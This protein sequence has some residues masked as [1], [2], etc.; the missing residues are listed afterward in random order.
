[1]TP[2]L[3]LAQTNHTELGW[4][5]SKLLGVTLTSAEWVLWVLV[6]L[7][8]LSIA[9]MLE[10]TVYFARH[11]LPD[12]EALAVRLAR[13]EYDVARKAIEGKTG[14]E[15][16]IIRE[17]LASADQGADTVEQVIASTLSRERPQYERFLSYLGT[18]GNNAPFIGLFGTVLGIIK[19]FNDLGKMNAQGGG[20][21]MQQTVM[22][23]ISE[24]LVATA[25][26]LA[27]AIPAVVAFNVFN[28]QLKTLTSRAN[29]LGYALVGSMRA[30]RPA[31][32]TATAARAAEAR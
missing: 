24:A 27:V 32:S 17:A 5:S 16:A 20:G 31:S 12:S 2:F 6:I 30:E 9:I 10:R 19:A 7:S 3:S 4:L 1:M 15:A 29:A 13:G 22:A 25:V 8:V 21:A 18:L 11:R 23:G 26:G 28:R 14:M